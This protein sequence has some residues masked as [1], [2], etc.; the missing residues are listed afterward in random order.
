MLETLS[1][2]F[3]T[4]KNLLSKQAELNER[5]IDEALRE[6]RVSLLEADV[7]YNVV[8]QF[9]ERVKEK[10][11][12]KQVLTSVKDKSGQRHKLG[13]AEHF[14]GICYEELEALMGPVDTSIQLSKPIGTIMMVGLQGSGKTTTTGKLAQYLKK[15]DLRPLLVAADIY[16][17]A[18]VQQL[19]V[20]GEQLQ[21]PVF[22]DPALLP[23]QLCQQ[24]LVK[25][26]E[27]QCNVVIFDTAGRL[28]IDDELMRELESIKALT[29][30]DN[31]FLV[32]DA[33]IGQDAV[34]TAA[35]FN[36]RLSIDGFILTKLDGDARGGSALSIKEVTGKPIKFLG[37]G[38]KLGNL[39][40]FRPQGLASRILGMGDIVSLVKDF[41]EHVDQDKAEQD[42]MRMLKGK[43]TLQDFLEQLSVIKKMGSFQSVIDKMPGMSEMLPAGKTV[44]DREFVKFESIVHSMT[45]KERVYPE[46]VEKQR[47]RKKRIALGCGRKE[48]DVD[49]LLKRFGMMKTMFQ[50]IGTQPG[51]LGRLPGFKQLGQ[52]ANMAKAMKGAQGMGFG[53]GG[54]MGMMP[55]GFGQPMRAATSAGAGAINNKDK[56]DKRKQQKMARKKNKKKK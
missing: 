15:K 6:V 36:R 37:M 20:L 52:M 30:P 38:E 40:E 28:A 3:R 19:K 27:L 33:M 39:E 5:N 21:V 17:P 4:A 55:P 9:L 56:K 7:E 42:A 44:D 46:L 50:A 25:A 54:P 31:I 26:K 18:A 10:A 2:G 43:F 16:R 49:S 41:E 53:A 14:V 12:G 34:R 22:A 13:P 32:V 29:K 1:Q 45:P 23:P 47:S 8:K 35:E 51:L 24:A 48:S 11:L